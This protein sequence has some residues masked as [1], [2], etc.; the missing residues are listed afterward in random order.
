[1]SDDST[2]IDDTCEDINDYQININKSKYLNEI[3]NINN[4]ELKNI[5]KLHTDNHINN[6][7][8]LDKIEACF[9]KKILNYSIIEQITLS[10]I[11]A[12]LENEL[13]ENLSEFYSFLLE[14]KFDEND[15]KPIR[16]IIKKNII[17]IKE[18]LNNFYEIILLIKNEIIINKLKIKEDYI[19][20]LI[21]SC[22]EKKWSL[23]NIII[24]LSNLQKLY[25]KPTENLKDEE[26][27]KT[28]KENEQKILTAKTLLNTISSFPEINLIKIMEKINFEDVNNIARD[29][30]IECAKGR[31]KNINELDTMKL[32]N[33]LQKLNKKY[34]HIDKINMFKT[35]I[36]IC[37]SY[38]TKTLDINLWINEELPN[39]FEK[40]ENK[41]IPKEFKKNINKAESIATILG[42]ISLALKKTKSKRGKELNLRTSQILSL[43]IFIDNHE[44]QE[45]KEQK[46]QKG[47][48]EEIATGEG[49]SIIILCLAA[50]FGLKNHKIDII[51]SSSILAERD[52]KNSVKFFEKLGLKV[53]YCKNSTNKLEEN[54]TSYDADILYGTFLSFEGDLLEEMRSNEEIR[55]NR[56]FDIIIIDEVD[57]AFIDCIEGSTQLSQSS[58]GYQFLLPM[59]ISIY[60]FVD[61]L[62]NLYLDE[63]TKQYDD[64]ISR[65]KFKNLDEISK[66]KILD[67]LSEDSDR[68][69]IFVNYIENYIRK[70][71]DEIDKEKINEYN[72]NTPKTIT[73]KLNDDSKLKNFFYYPH[74]LKE[75]VDTNLLL[76]IK[77]AFSAKNEM[78]LEKHYTL[79]SKISGYK[80]ITPIDKKNTGELEFNT[81]YKGGLHQMLQIKEKVRLLPETLDHTF[82]SHITYFSNYKY[83]RNFFGLT[84]TIGG[85]E[86]YPIY[87]NKYFNSNLIYIP[88]YIPK[89]F[90]ELPAIICEENY[91]NHL[92][93]ICQEI[94][95]HYSRGRKILVICQDIN[96]GLKLKELLE[97]E[98]FD[99]E[100]EDV[101]YK[102]DILLYLRND[103]KDIQD[104]L[105]KTKERIIISTNLGGRGT[106]INTTSEIE[107]KGGLHVIITKLSE[108]SRTQKQ[109]FGRT[110]RQGKKGSGQYIFK[111]E[112]GI[113]TYNQLIKNRNEKEKNLIKDIDNNLDYLL[114]KDNLFITYVDFIKHFKQLINENGKY[115]KSDID[116]QWA[117]FL[118]K[119]VDKSKDKKEIEDAFKKFRDDVKKI[120]ELQRYE[121]FKNNFLRILDAINIYDDF[122]NI[123]ELEKFFKFENDS[124]CFYFAS[125]YYMARVA[126]E[127][128]KK[129]FKENINRDDFCKEIVKYLKETKNKLN[130]LIEINIEPTLKSFIDWEKITEVDKMLQSG[131]FINI[132]DKSFKTQFTNR[133]I[134][135]NNLIQLVEQNIT[136]VQEYID[137]YLPT[138][139][140]G[141]EAV[142]EVE[143]EN[144]L[145]KSL[146]LS[147][148]YKNDV[149]DYLGDAGLIYTFKFIIKKKV[150]K[151]NLLNFF[152]YLGF[153]IFFSF[154]SMIRPLITKGSYESISKKIKVILSK[155]LNL[156]YNEENNSIFSVIKSKIF[157]FFQKKEKN[158]NK[159]NNQNNIYVENKG[160]YVKDEEK[161]LSMDELEKF[162][163]NTL[164]KIK[165]YIKDIFNENKKDIFEEIKFLLFIDY[166]FYQQNWNDIIKEIINDYFKQN[167]KLQKKAQL[168]KLCNNKES[169]ELA[170]ENLKNIIKESISDIIKT[171]KEKFDSNEYEENKIKKLEHIIIKDCGGDLDEKSVSDIVSQILSQKVIDENGIFNKNLFDEIAT[172]YVTWT[173]RGDKKSNKK[174]KN[175]DEKPKEQSIKIYY[176]TPYPQNFNKIDNINQL[177]LSFKFEE[178][179]DPFLQDVQLLYITRNYKSY[180][181]LIKKD[182]TKKIIDILNR[183]YNLSLLDFNEITEKFFNDISQKV[184]EI[185]EKYLNEEI[186][187][188]ILVK[189]E[190]KKIIKLNKEEQEIYDLISQNSGKKAIDLLESRDFFKQNK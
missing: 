71:L 35:Q 96:E 164:E 58:K 135:I 187:D 48:I 172:P 161:L 81:N 104:K 186:F 166:Y 182:F 69:E 111:E 98:K 183:L 103:D 169:H 7:N 10:A 157:S 19:K 124:Q 138:N 119:N 97:K 61:I 184:E 91:E 150:M 15:Y 108:N 175:L 126:F 12:S 76:W 127:K 68:K 149:K 185:I 84:G 134:I 101:N 128:H 177:S 52:A 83:K 140:K 180:G 112:K 109:A 156:D 59:Y 14:K 118:S 120:N 95:F 25:I 31:D 86:T 154:L 94:I 89:R 53:S 122:S 49:K 47:I 60:F 85:E 121:K 34:F 163:I 11:E 6:I 110:S 27:L 152:L 159:E 160:L 99:L 162:E 65:E 46:D 136:V 125:S 92:I 137:K 45:N 33:S 171:I 23:D 50:Y 123:P 30:Y 43:L 107:E 70:I 57:N 146:R 63:V 133:K 78:M 41:T 130:K 105:N 55:H 2:N 147:D 28:I 102:K 139:I 179:K 93:K 1:M 129:Q 67:K 79:S 88:S 32:L 4:N 21:N 73:Q 174:D 106:D 190:N 5:I 155:Y 37:K 100:Y 113:K 176:N 80:A 153:F 62:D 9:E 24:F 8:L 165:K 74:C 40:N 115:I 148:E 20:D 178:P 3:E 56:V 64:L 132:S 151:R 90:I 87:K 26:L 75:F 117:L 13:V 39:Y 189:K 54:D 181:K 145:V 188:N 131:N 72:Y 36:E 38:L 168:I 114:L 29:F 66:K 158:I 18:D 144:D 51:T 143:K 82:M 142:L 173:N 116:E 17:K 42:I 22:V 170:V 77:S 167:K 141:W 44:S 16:E